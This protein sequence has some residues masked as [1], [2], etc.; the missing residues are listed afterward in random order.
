VEVAQRHI[1]LMV[2]GLMA[3]SGSCAPLKAP[4]APAAQAYL[5]VETLGLGEGLV[6]LLARMRAPESPEAL[7]AYARCAAAGY[8]QEKGYGFARHVRTQIAEEGEGIWRA[9]AVYTMSRALPPGAAKI[10]TEV[11]VAD[12][13]G[14]G[15]PTV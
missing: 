14:R 13:A 15:I 3:G 5:G 11:T 2:F 6:N 9:D 1:T 10:D 7:R 8:A 4:E 12:C